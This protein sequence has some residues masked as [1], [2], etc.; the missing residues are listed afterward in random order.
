MVSVE[1]FK[2]IARVKGIKSYILVRNDGNIAAHNIDDIAPNP[3][4]TVT[5][6]CGRRCTQLKQ[7]DFKCLLFSKKNNE[8]IFIFP[9]GNYYLGVIKESIIDEIV[10]ID[11]IFDFIRSLPRK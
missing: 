9:V 1:A 2:R 5:L 11:N 8:N 7:S 6:K 10:L 4:T 3:L